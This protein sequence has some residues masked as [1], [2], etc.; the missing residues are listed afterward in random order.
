MVVALVGIAGVYGLVVSS[1]STEI[2]S[3]NLAK[4]NSIARAKTEELRNV[5][6][7]NGGSLTSDVSGYNDSPIAGYT[8]RWQIS[9]DAIGTKIV[10]VTVIP[11]T[12]S[13]ILP[14]VEITTRMK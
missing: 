8:R 12:P 3:R 13:I 2:T 11:N 1:I 4:A 10:Q 6:R 7:T 14:Q 5:P 9:N